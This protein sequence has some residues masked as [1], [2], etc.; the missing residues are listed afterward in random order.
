MHAAFRLFASTEN[1]PGIKGL[2]HSAEKS[3]SRV[4]PILGHRLSKEEAQ[5]WRG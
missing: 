1:D 2:A 4:V 5:T 3:A